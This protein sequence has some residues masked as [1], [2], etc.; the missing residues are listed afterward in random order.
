MGD[1]CPPQ[2]YLIQSIKYRKPPFLWYIF[3]DWK[4]IIVVTRL[5]MRVGTKMVDVIIHEEK[6]IENDS[7]EEQL[8]EFGI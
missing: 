7:V 4:Y 5:G 3:K 2:I 1:T 6:L 8:V